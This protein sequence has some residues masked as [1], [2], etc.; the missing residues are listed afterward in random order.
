ME[1]DQTGD[2]RR[3]IARIVGKIPRG[4]IAY[5]RFS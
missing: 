3:G 2:A 5:L 1:V 4:D